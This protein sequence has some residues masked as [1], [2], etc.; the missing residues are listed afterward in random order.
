MDDPLRILRCFRFSITKEFT[1]DDSIWKAMT[2]PAILQKLEL[3]VSSERIRDEIFKMMK[4]DTVATIKLLNG[5]DDFCIPGF[6]DLVFGRGLWL[7][8]TNEL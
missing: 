1:I 2:N 4:H 7:K 6:L 8:P 3:T 5:I